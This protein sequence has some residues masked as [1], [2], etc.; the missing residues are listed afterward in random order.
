LNPSRQRASANDHDLV[1]LEEQLV[2]ELGDSK[3]DGRRRDRSVGGRTAISSPSFPTCTFLP[4][5]ANYSS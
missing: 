3:V 2:A 1:A 5:Q 4:A